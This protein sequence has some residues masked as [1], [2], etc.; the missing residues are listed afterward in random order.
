MRVLG[1]D[2]ALQGEMFGAGIQKNPYK[3][4]DRQVLWFS[5]YDITKGER[6]NFVEMNAI[7]GELMLSSVPVIFSDKVS[8]QNVLNR[9]YWIS[10]AEGKSV[11][12]DTQREGIVVRIFDEYEYSFKAI[13][14]KYLL[15]LE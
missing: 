14:N 1:K 7:L 12:G 2:I 10:L 13:S 8:D 15:S 11:L 3:M 9:D 5:A 6:L 4:K